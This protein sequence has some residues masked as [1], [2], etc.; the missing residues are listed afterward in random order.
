MQA[1]QTD[2]KVQKDDS[3]I[4]ASLPRPRGI[5]GRVLAG[6]ERRREP[7][8]PTNCT[9]LVRSLNPLAPGRVFA[10]VIDVSRNGMK[11]HLGTSFYPGTTIHI[12]LRATLLIGEVRYSKPVGGG[13]EHGIAIAVENT[14]GG[15]R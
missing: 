3:A 9:A 6:E 12:F 2:V 14:V 4:A 15:I 7:R 10:K 1:C 5:T 8:Y 13:F 11:L